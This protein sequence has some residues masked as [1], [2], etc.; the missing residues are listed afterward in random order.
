M[1]WI[2]TKDKF[3]DNE[4][5]DYLVVIKYPS[6]QEQMVVEWWFDGDETYQWMPNINGTV[7]HEVTHWK[8]L[9]ELPSE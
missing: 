7:P 1:A 2:S 6:R 5:K 4:Q 8:E 9:G 3:P